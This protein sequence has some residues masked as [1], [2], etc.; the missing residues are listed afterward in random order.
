MRRLLVTA[1]VVPRSAILVTLMMEAL[2]SSESSALTRTTRRNIL[3]DGILHI[4][5]RKN[6][7]SYTHTHTHTYIYIYIYM[8]ICVYIYIY[9]YLGEYQND[10]M[11]NP[12]V[13]FPTATDR[14]LVAN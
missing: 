4:N 7:K 13:A 3:E 12:G 14:K 1:K 2:R 8:Y 9:V 5:R 6:L 10:G 11:V